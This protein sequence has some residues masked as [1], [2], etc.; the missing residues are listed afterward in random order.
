M[1]YLPPWAPT[2]GGGHYPPHMLSPHTTTTS[3]HSPHTSHSTTQP[4][5][6]GSVYQNLS[7]VV[8]SI[9]PASV[10]VTQSNNTPKSSTV[11]STGSSSSPTSV[12]TS[13]PSSASSI[14]IG[15]QYEPQG[16][17][18]PYT[19]PPKRPDLGDGLKTENTSMGDSPPP[20]MLLAL[21]GP[22]SLDL[23]SPRKSP[24]KY[25]APE[26]LASPVMFSYQGRGRPRKNWTH[27]TGL[28]TMI[29]VTHPPMHPVSVDDPDDEE[30]KPF[31]CNIC[32]K[33]FKLKGG[34][35][36]HERTHSTDRPYVCPDCGKLFRQP[37]HLQQHIRIHTGDKPYD[38]AFCDKS[39][40]QRTILNQH[41]RIHTGEKPYVCMECGKQFRQ[42]AILDQH[43][44]T[45]L[46]EKPYA[47][48]HPSCR[49]HFRE[50][51]TLISH[52]QCHKDVTDP[53]IVLQQAKR[54]IKEEQNDDVRL[55][56]QGRE[57]DGSDRRIG[58]ERVDQDREMGENRGL[59]Q[60]G[61]GQNRIGQ[62]R[63]MGQDVINQDRS[64]GQ[65]HRE[66]VGSNSEQ[67]GYQGN[68][69]QVRH[70]HRSF[71]LQSASNNSSTH[72]S[73]HSLP[74]HSNTD[75]QRENSSAPPHSQPPS[76]SPNMMPTPQM[77]MTNLIPYPHSIFPATSYMMPPPDPRQYHPQNQGQHPSRPNQ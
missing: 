59:G 54:M 43:F 76:I 31:K 48:P 24:G 34:L 41:L 57:H 67:G 17:K 5:T 60:D 50:M 61:M 8:K 77:A 26:Q 63:G 40:R 74:M 71:P 62:E 23:K 69:E 72:K 21:A 70:E 32:K 39:F 12:P 38:C 9:S 35:M 16:F 14:S 73:P 33:G 44:R 27:S 15:D 18:R 64:H 68:G 53:R 19:P 56:N 46:G 13:A 2:S 3:P 49:K 22:S 58:Q 30:N 10:S 52:M 11:P 7:P 25:P 1:S 4:N 20:E 47:C 65:D 55:G 36:Q 66:S 75:Q 37:T 6:S 42:K 29:P 28:P 51:A 45:H